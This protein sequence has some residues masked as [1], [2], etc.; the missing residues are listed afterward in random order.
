[1]FDESDPKFLNIESPVTVVN[2]NNHVSYCSYPRMGNS[3]LRQYLQKVTGIATGSDMALEFCHDLQGSH[4]KGEE[5]IDAS[6]W[7][8]KSHD[9]FY[10]GPTSVPNKSNKVIN[11]VRNPFDTIA[12]TMC[13]LP[14]LIQSEEYNE[15]FNDFPEQFD[16]FIRES[17]EGLKEYHERVTTTQI[18]KTVPTLI[19]RYEDLRTDPQTV[20]EQIFCF[21]LDVESVEGLN[22]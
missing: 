14:T 19:I 5:T 6:V 7:I 12:S 4:F 15:R 20:L 3:F 2:Q 17:V 9:P 16:K 22:I 21:L 10:T 11:C 18:A 8:K 13:F 1:M